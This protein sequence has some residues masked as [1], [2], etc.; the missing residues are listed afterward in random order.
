MGDVALGCVGKALT[1]LREQVRLF[2]AVLAACALDDVEH[3]SGACVTAGSALG[4]VVEISF[5]A[6]EKFPAS[7]RLSACLMAGSLL[8][9]AVLAPVSASSAARI[10]PAMS[11]KPAIVKIRSILI[12]MADRLMTR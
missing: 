10:E 8:V 9:N 5:C 11:I 6:F 7:S 3:L 4:W 12:G 2:K 1:N